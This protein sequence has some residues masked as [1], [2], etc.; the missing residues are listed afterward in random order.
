MININNIGKDKLKK[1]LPVDN[2]NDDISDKTDVDNSVDQTTEMDKNTNSL[3]LPVD[4]TDKVDKMKLMSQ[5][6]QN[7]DDVDSSTYTFN[8][9]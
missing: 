5:C 6:I 2:N 9:F 8:L 4:S 3:M 1:V 7:L